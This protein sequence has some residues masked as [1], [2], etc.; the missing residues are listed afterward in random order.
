MNASFFLSPWVTE[1][2]RAPFARVV[3]RAPTQGLKQHH[4]SREV[5][6]IAQLQSC[7]L[8]LRLLLCFLPALR[9]GT[10][11]VCEETALPT[12]AIRN[13]MLSVTFFLL[14][15]QSHAVIVIVLYWL[16]LLVESQRVQDIDQPPV[17]GTVR[18]TRVA[19]PLRHAATPSLVNGRLQGTDNLS[20]QFSSELRRR[21]S[22]LQLRSSSWQFKI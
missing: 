4:Y 19:P 1:L 9:R 7:S 20:C 11:R 2:K 15:G 16:I 17:V 8:R 5:S 14:F 10:M 21:H 3:H 12:T 13:T 18:H 6:E 22:N